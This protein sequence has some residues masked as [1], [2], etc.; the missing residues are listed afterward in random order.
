MTR[1]V[2]TGFT[3]FGFLICCFLLLL[4]ILGSILFGVTDIPF[5]KFIEAYQSFNGS[6]EHLIIR[7]TRVP[8]A[9]IAAAVGAAL[10]VS[11]ALMQALTRNPLASPSLFGINSGAALFIV[12]ASGYLGV[13]GLQSFTWIAFLGAAVSAFS[14]Y[15]LGSIGREGMTPVQVTLAGAAVTALFSSMTQGILLSNGKAFD[16]VLYWLVGSVAGRELSM[17]TTVLPYML[18]GFAAAL[19]ISRHI[20]I[21]SM[22]EDVAKGLGQRTVLIKLGAA[23]VIVLLAGGAVSVAGPIAFVGLIIPHVTRFLIGTDYRWIIPYC[24]V[25]GAILLVGADLGSRYIAMPKE[26]PVGVMTAIIGVPFF[27]YIA[28]KGATV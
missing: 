11:G 4:C 1:P 13:S 28:R 27:V 3:I 10:A 19:L 18:I 26:V 2:R 5:P 12:I 16:Q 22:G 14:V 9:F 7:N 25:L 8:R 17:L 24:A 15:G 23:A 21:L 20:N 6:N